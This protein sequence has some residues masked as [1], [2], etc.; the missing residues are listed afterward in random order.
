MKFSDKD[1]C[2][3]CVFGNGEFNSQ[4]KIRLS[5]VENKCPCVEC[6]L[7]CICEN[8]CDTYK[9]LIDKIME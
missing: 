3:G 7:K 1:I 5:E 4:C 8:Y 2:R 9:E 6:L